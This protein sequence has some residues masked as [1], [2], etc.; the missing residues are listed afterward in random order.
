MNKELEK[1]F[2]RG[3]ARNDN[4]KLKKSLLDICTNLPTT[5]AKLFL[6]NLNEGYYTYEPTKSKYSDNDDYYYRI[7]EYKV[8]KITRVKPILEENSAEFLFKKT[9]KKLQELESH[10]TNS[11]DDFL[12]EKIKQLRTP[13]LYN[14]YN[15]IEPLTIILKEMTD[16]IKL[17]KDAREQQKKL[18]TV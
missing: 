3:I 15:S 12:L 14:W 2:E 9:I 1:M 16:N 11:D 18:N 10:L 4:P 8:K 7:N 13:D 5:Q 17:E 6:M